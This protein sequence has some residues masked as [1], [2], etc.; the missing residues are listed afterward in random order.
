MHVHTH[1]KN[2]PRRQSS[3]EKAEMFVFLSLKSERIQKNAKYV[4]YE[5][6]AEEPSVM[7]RAT[8]PTRKTQEEFACCKFITSFQ[9][10]VGQMPGDWRLCVCVCVH[11]FLFISFVFKSSVLRGRKEIIPF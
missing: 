1:K 3:Q 2:T 8:L 9:C 4:Q 6:G 10:T 7:R 11:A 5:T